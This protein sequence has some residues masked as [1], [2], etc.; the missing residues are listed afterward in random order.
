MK[1]FFIQTN[2]IRL[3]SQIFPDSAS[4]R[5]NILKLVEIFG[6]IVH[7]P[8]LLLINEGYVLDTRDLS[9]HVVNPTKLEQHS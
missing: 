8:H 2:M 6:N 9:L 4:D 7:N 3:S 1:D 5:L